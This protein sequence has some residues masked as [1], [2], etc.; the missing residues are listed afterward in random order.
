MKSKNWVSKDFI[1]AARK[2]HGNRFSYD[3]VEYTGMTNDVAITCTVHGDFLQKAR[4]HLYGTS[5]KAC[6]KQHET[7][8]FLARA[9]AV[10]GDLYDYSK[11]DYVHSEKKVI[12][13]CKVHGDFLQTPTAHWRLEQGC[14][15][16]SGERNKERCTSNSEDFIAKA[17]VA[18][19][20]RYDYSLVDYKLSR[21]PVEIVCT[22]C[23]HPFWQTPNAH[24]AGNGCR[25]CNISGFTN[26]KSSFLY[27]LTSGNI[28]KVG[29]T[30]K[31]PTARA[32][33]ISSYAGRD[34][35]VYKEYLYEI[36]KKAL[37]TENS[38]LRWMRKKYQGVQE[39]FQGYTE[40]FL[41]VDREELLSKLQ[42]AHEAQAA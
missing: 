33:I 9:K 37:E 2:I 32:K 27:I 7:D 3:N 22:S 24:L 31:T 39:K 13:G 28:T 21:E 6:T 30:N 38:T 12:I 29:I 15:K 18:H 19:K 11:L 42:A 14:V 25:N 8:K 1:D 10:H 34:F 26:L 4:N 20:G 17:S 5:C 16:C 35:E 40:C 41:D 36:G 23:S